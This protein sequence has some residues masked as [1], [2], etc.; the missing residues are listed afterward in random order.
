M[1][2]RP[3]TLTAADAE[4]AAC[5]QHPELDWFP[6][7]GQVAD[8]AAAK[9]VCHACPVEAPCLEAALA[10]AEA[11]DHGIL[12]GT[13]RRERIRIRAARRRAARLKAAR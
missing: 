11:N 2:A 7:S 4:L 8:A 12:G 3:I 6:G 9:A 1:R 5:R 10:Q 13:G